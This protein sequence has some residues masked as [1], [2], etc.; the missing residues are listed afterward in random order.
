MRVRGPN[1]RRGHGNGLAVADWLPGWGGR[2][3]NRRRG[4]GNA[5]VAADWLPGRHCLPG[6]AGQARWDRVPTVTSAGD[7]PGVAG[8]S[9]QP[10]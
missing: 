2:G 7:P 9:S 4:H 5:W 10:L 1:T 3:P 6:R 8:S